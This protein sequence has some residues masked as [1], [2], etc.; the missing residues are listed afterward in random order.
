MH[1]ILRAVQGIIYM[2]VI[3][4]YVLQYPSEPG[5]DK[6]YNLL[7][8]RWLMMV[9]IFFGIIYFGHL[10]NT[11]FFLNGNLDENDLLNISVIPFIIGVLSFLGIN[12]LIFYYPEILTGE[13]R[14]P[15]PRISEIRVFHRA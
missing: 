9:A 3:I 15:I 10:V 12:G 6:D 11:L 2:S 14:R 8:T 5:K 13:I 4:I 1:P 7:I